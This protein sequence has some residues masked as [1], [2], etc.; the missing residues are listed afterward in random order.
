M[1][2]KAKRVECEGID[3][4]VNPGDFK[5]MDNYTRMMFVCPCGCGILPGIVVQPLPNA[6]GWD[7][8]IETPTITPSIDINRGHWHGYLTNGVFKSCD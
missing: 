7:G 3:C 1:E 2:I 5:W 6:W 8:N 4:L